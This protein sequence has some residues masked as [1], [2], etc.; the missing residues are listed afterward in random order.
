MDLQSLHDK[1]VAALQKQVNLWHAKKSCEE[2]LSLAAGIHQSNTTLKKKYKNTKSK[3]DLSPFCH[4]LE[5]DV[6]KKIA[7]VE[8]KVTMEQLVKKVLECNLLVPVIPE[9]KGI[10]VGGAI[11]GAA[12]ES[13]S[14][15]Y[16]L[17]NDICNSYEVL[18][19]DGTIVRASK[20]ENSDLFYGIAGSYGSIGTI[21]KVEI[22]LIDAPVAIKVR[23]IPFDDVKKALS[24]LTKRCQNSNEL[25][26]LDGI[27]FSDTFAMV[28]EGSFLHTDELIPKNAF[29]DLSAIS[30]EWFYQHAAKKSESEEFFLVYDY[31]F[32][33]DQGAF[34]M[35]SYLFKYKFLFRFLIEGLCNISKRDAFSSF[36]KDEICEFVKIHEQP[37]FF[38]RLVGSYLSSKRL[39]GMLHKNEKWV[40]TKCIIQDFFVP[41]SRFKE[42]YEQIAE[43]PKV[44]PL[45][46]CPV[47][48]MN[49]DQIFS[50]HNTST[51][52]SHFINFGIYGIPGKSSPISELTKT[53]ELEVAK[54]GGRKV[55]YSKSY[56][57]PEEFWNT[58]SKTAYDAL[59][60]KYQANGTWLS[61]EQKLLDT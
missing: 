43:S 58:Y 2:T 22:Q 54:L 33:Y 57:T 34:W 13:S 60:K 21:L 45:W 23:Y 8:P 25:E 24:Y 46:L 16:G 15:K 11:M 51:S 35:G 32:R 1:N 4:I 56:Y 18:L 48:K 40:E 7:I 47:K 19:G 41:Q 14:F 5:L 37:S 28:M 42:F 6:Q 61:I 31:L 36:N 49:Q 3:I 53:L 17:F 52:D 39:Y 27:A 55:L 9:F 26:Y 50:P 20:D 30:S 44:W 38:E 59:R 29:C 10:T 12:G